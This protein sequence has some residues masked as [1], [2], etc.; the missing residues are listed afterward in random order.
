M[1]K[2]LM[3]PFI[4]LTGS[5]LI[6][7][8]AA[9]DKPSGEASG[10]STQKNISIVWWGS[11]SRH[12]KTLDVIKLFETAYPDIKV[13]PEYSGMDGYF[14]KL[15]VQIAGGSAPDVIQYG[16]DYVEYVKMDAFLELDKYL[17]NQLDLS[18]FEPDMIDSGR[19]YG[20][21]YGV[22]LGTNMPSLIYNKSL[23]E[24]AG[25][26]LPNQIMTWE[27]LA[28][29]CRSI[30]P[31][32]P[33]G[34]YPMA[35][36]SSNQTIYLSY[37]MRQNGTPIYRNETTQATAAALQKWIELWEGFRAEKL[38]PDAETSA[39][40]PETGVDNSILVAGRAVIGFLWSN[41]LLAYQG[42]MQDEL[43]MI[44]LPDIEKK[45]NWVNPSQ[46]MCVYKRSP[47]A[48]A[49]VTFINFFV[50][51][52]EAGKILGTD[53]GTPC[54]S[55]VRDAY[56]PLA[57]PVDQKIFEYYSVAAKYTSSRDLNLPNDQEFISTFKLIAQRVAFGQITAQEG[58]KQSYELIQRM[59]AK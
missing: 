5:V 33:A 29:Y 37:F 19:Y 7:A 59:L 6:F 12:Q 24:R 21:L 45:Q 31:K 4:L 41:Q 52:V 38:I 51:D 50:N 47:N 18:K 3:V 39:S 28:A 16:G 14:D 13:S 30:A 58:G 9:K 53:R 34:V 11:D 10:A 48:E 20:S 17:G 42:A 43:G 36:N 57:T 15:N 8:G 56:M 32:L 35:D 27:Q 22:C 44:Q 2:L 54:S 1:K 55:K 23:L 26:P 25:I 40:Y 46:A 49:A